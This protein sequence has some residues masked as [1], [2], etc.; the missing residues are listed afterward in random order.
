MPDRDKALAWALQTS[1]PSE[2][3]RSI[4]ERAEGYASFVSES[5]ACASPQR[6]ASACS[7]AARGLARR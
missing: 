5:N 4:L 2:N 6:G 1:T 7:E 3:P